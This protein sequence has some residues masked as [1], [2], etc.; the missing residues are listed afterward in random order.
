MN[1]CAV[2]PAPFPIILLSNLFIALE[3]V[4][5]AIL[6]TNPGKLF[7]AKGITRSVTNV[8]T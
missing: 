2:L 3:A 6:L 7:L 5:E 1:P 4:F 8:F